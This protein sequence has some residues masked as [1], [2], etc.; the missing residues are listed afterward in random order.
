MTSAMKEVMVCSTHNLLLCG[1]G[2]RGFF[3]A[4]F[5]FDFA[6]SQALSYDGYHSSIRVLYLPLFS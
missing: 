5:N 2:S 4:P 1:K 3:P 6:I